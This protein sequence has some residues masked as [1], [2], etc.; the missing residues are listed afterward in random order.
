M[1]LKESLGEKKVNNEDIED[2]KQ[3]HWYFLC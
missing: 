1:N 3:F 2:T